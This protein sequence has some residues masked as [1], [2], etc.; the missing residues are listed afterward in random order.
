[1]LQGI[2]CASVDG[3]LIAMVKLS[4]ME[5]TKLR[6]STV[7]DIVPSYVSVLHVCSGVYSHYYLSLI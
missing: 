3:K 2:F 7:H 5:C 1:M 6:P 4:L